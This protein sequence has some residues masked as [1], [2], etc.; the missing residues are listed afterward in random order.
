MVWAFLL[1]FAS[2]TDLNTVSQN[3]VQKYTPITKVHC[4]AKPADNITTINIYISPTCLHCAKFIVEDLE[5][6]LKNND[7]FHVIINFLPASAKDIFIIK[8][9]NKETHD[10]KLFF[11]IFK[12]YIKRILATINS[13]KPSDEQLDLF[14]GS[15]SDPEMIK[16][17]VGA[18]EFGFSEAKVINA[19][20]KMKEE[21]ERAILEDYPKT[22]TYLSDILGI[23]EIDLPLIVINDKAYKSLSDI[24]SLTN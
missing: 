4:G 24:K 5:E 9:I 22:A 11:S 14:K 21:F 16:L 23:K 2:A 10:E 12:N 7:K 19:Y 20:P 6:F 3:N 17:Q 13:I 1:H 8:L 15:K 18:Y